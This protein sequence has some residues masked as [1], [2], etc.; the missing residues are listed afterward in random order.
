MLDTAA[1]DYAWP[2]YDFE[3]TDEDAADYEA[4]E[5]EWSAEYESADDPPPAGSPLY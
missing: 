3:P 5:I 2:E 4:Q 1:A